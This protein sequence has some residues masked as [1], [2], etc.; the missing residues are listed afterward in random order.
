M[1][2]KSPSLS[3]DQQYQAFVS[4]LKARF[5]AVCVIPI[6]LPKPVL[7]AQQGVN[8][9]A[10]R[11]AA[12]WYRTHGKERTRKLRL[13]AIPSKVRIHHVWFCAPNLYEAAARKAG[14]KISKSKKGH[15]PMDEANATFT[16]KHAIDGIVDAKLIKDDNYKFVTWGTFLRLGSV[17]ENFGKC[18]I[19]L[20]I[21]VLN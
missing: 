7:M 12:E 18:G 16:L 13:K 6:D 14:A 2:T 3:T 1:K 4:E 10:R 8:P 19:L 9:I 17:K 15:R 20:F 21:E 11:I 5:N